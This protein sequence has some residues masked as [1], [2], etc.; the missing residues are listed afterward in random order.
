MTRQSEVNELSLRIACIAGNEVHEGLEAQETG[1]FG[2]EVLADQ[3]R[4]DPK[5]SSSLSEKLFHNTTHDYPIL[6]QYYYNYIVRW[7]TIAY[8]LLLDPKSYTCFLVKRNRYPCSDILAHGVV[9]SHPKLGPRVRQVGTSKSAVRDKRWLS[10]TALVLIEKFAFANSSWMH[11]SSEF[12]SHV[13]SADCG[14][15]TSKSGSPSIE[16]RPSCHADSPFDQAKLTGPSQVLA[17]ADRRPK[18]PEMRARKQ[19]TLSEVNRLSLR[20]VHRGIR[21]IKRAREYLRPE[22]PVLLGC[23]GR[24]AA[25]TC[26]VTGRHAGRVAGDPGWG[27]GCG[28]DLPS[29]HDPLFENSRNLG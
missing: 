29:K 17:S 27:P 28:V 3:G 24:G 23:R 11:K 22:S 20:K 6:L 4:V 13:R 18:A 5:I 14:I 10:R 12:V 21:A 2:A 9:I 1:R 8:S 19:Y 26:H 7:N 25:R 16:S 15:E